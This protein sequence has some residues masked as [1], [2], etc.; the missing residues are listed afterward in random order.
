MRQFRTLVLLAGIAGAWA[1]GFGSAIAQEQPSSPEAREALK[2]AMM[3]EALASAKYKLFAEHARKAG[4]N[5]LADLL[6]ATSNQ[7]YGHFLRWAALYHL[8]GTDVQNLRTAAHDEVDEDVKLYTR[9]ASEA[10]ARGEKTLADHFKDVK[11]QEIIHQNEFEAAVEKA[12][13]SD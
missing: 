13:K 11:A 10:E 3:N 8:V 4:K 1:L 5:E 9:L 6:A 12:I 2:A 7:E